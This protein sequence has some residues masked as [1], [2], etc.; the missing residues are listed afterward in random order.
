MSSEG[1]HCFQHTSCGRHVANETIPLT[2]A[3]YI[4]LLYLDKGSFSSLLDFDICDQA[5][6]CS[7]NGWNVIILT[8]VKS[9]DIMERVYN[10]SQ[11]VKVQM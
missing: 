5:K 1:I 11:M 9:V 8:C 7:T 3:S 4:P 10:D 6:H 2:R